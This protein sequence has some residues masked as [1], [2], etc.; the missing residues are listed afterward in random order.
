MDGEPP[1]VDGSTSNFLF[2]F[3]EVKVD[4]INICH[5]SNPEGDRVP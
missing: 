1:L 5:W 2:Y 4:P 3:T